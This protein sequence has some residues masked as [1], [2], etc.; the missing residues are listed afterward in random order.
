MKYFFIFAVFVIAAC[1]K[2][3]ALYN[4]YG[5]GPYNQAPGMGGYGQPPTGV[6]SL[7]APSVSNQSQCSPYG[8]S[9]CY[10]SMGLPSGSGQHCYPFMPIYQGMQYNAQSQQDWNYT[11]TAWNQYYPY[12]GQNPYDL[13]GF[14]SFC[15]DYWSGTPYTRLIAYMDFYVYPWLGPTTQFLP[16]VNPT[17]FWMGYNYFPY[18]QCGSGSGG[19]Y[20]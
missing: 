19:C 16:Y 17:Q 1:G 7:Q 6:P 15:D 13:Y 3:D 2:N 5:Y 10:T 9:G 20:Y 8:Q 4:Q 14:L 12:Y 11:W 18:Y